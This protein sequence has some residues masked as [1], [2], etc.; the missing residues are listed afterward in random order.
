VRQGLRSLASSGPGS[1][2]SGVT[3][4]MLMLGGRRAARQGFRTASA[5]LAARGPSAA[6]LRLRGA[7][8]DLRLAAQ[9]SLAQ[10]ALALGHIDQPLTRAGAQGRDGNARTQQDA[11]A[12]LAG[13]ARGS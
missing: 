8:R 6:A 10:R 1:A 5:A 2:M 7:A 4:Q 9:G 3:P 11:R 12:G 13:D